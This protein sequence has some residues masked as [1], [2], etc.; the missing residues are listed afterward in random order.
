MLLQLLCSQLSVAIPDANKNLIICYKSR[1]LSVFPGE[2]LRRASTHSSAED[3]IMRF[4]KH[5][6]ERAPC[7]RRKARATFNTGHFVHFKARIRRRA[8]SP[9]APIFFIPAF[10]R[11]SLALAAPPVDTRAHQISLLRALFFFAPFRS[12]LFFSPR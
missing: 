2:I 7:S 12:L 1:G 9:F 8:P 4:I 5:A 10:S 3:R 6:L 11:H